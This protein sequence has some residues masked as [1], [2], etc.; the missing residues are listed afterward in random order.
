MKVAYGDDVVGSGL[1]LFRL[2]GNEPGDTGV[3]GHP[4]LAHRLVDRNWSKPDAPSSRRSAEQVL[5]DRFGAGSITA[6][7]YQDRLGALSGNRG[8]RTPRWRMNGAPR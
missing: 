2:A 3:L 4:H 1:K 6:V 7:Q 8:G 5:A